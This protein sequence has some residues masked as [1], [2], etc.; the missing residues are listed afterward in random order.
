MSVLVISTLAGCGINKGSRSWLKMKYQTQ[1][2][3][4][5]QKIQKI[6]LEKFSIGFR[7]YQTKGVI[8]EN[9]KLKVSGFE[10]KGNKNIKKIEGKSKKG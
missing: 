7:I 1:K 8:E 5:Q 2:K 4:I 3:S 10:M 9:G 6:Y